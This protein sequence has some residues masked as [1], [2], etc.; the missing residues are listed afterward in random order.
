MLKIIQVCVLTLFITFA[1]IGHAKSEA[2]P[3]TPAQPNENT[4]KNAIANAKDHGFLWKISKNNHTSYLY[5]TIHV[6]TFDSMFPGPTVTKALNSTDVIALELDMLDADIQSRMQKKMQGMQTHKIPDELI[7]RLKQSA[8][9]ECVSYDTIS[10]MTP[11]LQVTTLVL[12]QSRRDQLESAYGID[13]VLAG[14]GHSAKKSVTSLETPEMQL[15]LLQ[16]E[17]K[18][19]TI[20]FVKENLDLLKSGQSRELTKRAFR[21]WA[22]SD[23]QDLSQYYEW[24][25]CME[26]ER[27]RKFMHRMLDERN[28]GLAD[29]IN[30]IHAS[31]KSVFAAVG[32]LHMVDSHGLPILMRKLGYHVEK[33]DFHNAQ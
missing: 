18:D 27:D 15:D 9:A 12:L 25:A 16:M 5:G 1:N 6:A 20:D 31:G 33:V 10:S 13:M 22:H 32:S 7:E 8:E 23:Y 11:E 30:I 14:W 4:I 29:S 19:E 17:T 3:A 28:Q 21:D 24:C 26:T 2:C